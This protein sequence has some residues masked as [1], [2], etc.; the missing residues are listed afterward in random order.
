MTVDEVM[1]ELERLGN[2]GT[3]KVLMRHGAREPFF[4]S[5]DRG[6]EKASQAIQGGSRLGV[7]AV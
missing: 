1:P 7:G 6:S 4:W 5:E 3:K 2:P